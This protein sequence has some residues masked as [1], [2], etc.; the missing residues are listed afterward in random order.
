MSA[1]A[2]VVAG[3]VILVAAAILV[4]ASS[5]Q[6]FCG[7]GVGLG[8]DGF[9]VER[10]IPGSGAEKVGLPVG[11]HIVSIDGK[12]T[13]G[14]TLEEVQ[15]LLRGPAGTTVAV[16][17]VQPPGL[18]RTYTIER[19]QLTLVGPD[20]L[21]GSY[22]FQ[23]DPSVVVVIE[24]VNDCQFTARCEKQHWAGMGLVGNNTFKGVFQMADHPEVQEAFRGT[25]SFFR[26]DF[27]F[28]DM[29]TLKSRFNFFDKADKIV[30]RTLVRKK[31]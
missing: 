1:R 28:G 2:G 17:V 16:G 26:I 7:V 8:R 15:N 22:A 6:S 3:G 21:A 19:R 20:T 23:D 10:V 5:T 30:E 14:M 27:G 24:R 13:Q 12:P 9:N 4:A 18:A 11:C 31:G 25:V 29:L